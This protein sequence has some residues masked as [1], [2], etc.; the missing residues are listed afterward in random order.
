M[1]HTRRWVSLAIVTALLVPLA[2]AADDKKADTD[3]PADKKAVKD[4]PDKKDTKK[5]PGKKDPAQ[6][7]FEKKLKEENDK[8]RRSKFVE[9]EVVSV[10]GS[11]KTLSIN[12]TVKLPRIN[13]AEVEAF[14]S[15]QRDYVNAAAGRN[16]QGMIQAR[17]AMAQHQANL[18][19]YESHPVKLD[20]EAAADVIVRTAEPPVEYDEKTGKVKRY[21][22][23]ELRA[24]KGPENRWGFP[25]DFDTLKAQQIVR[26]YLTWPKAAPRPRAADKDTD[27]D[28]LPGRQKATANTIYILLDKEK[29]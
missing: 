16:V 20:L 14:A 29:K 25:A 9:G 15:S 21:T 10:E 4:E 1:W 18:I 23:K 24:L 2:R 3:K 19:T 7:Q 27:K 13:P 12:V 17:A 28:L 6:Q 11:H 22:A 8:L 26:V 5:K